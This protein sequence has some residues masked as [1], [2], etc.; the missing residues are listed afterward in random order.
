LKFWYED[1]TGK[2]NGMGF[3]LTSDGDVTHM[4]QAAQI[5]LGME[6]I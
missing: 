4:V 1:S 6:M 5:G 3:V 2:K